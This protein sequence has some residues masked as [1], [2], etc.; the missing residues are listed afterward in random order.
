MTPEGR[1]RLMEAA[2]RLR[3]AASDLSIAAHKADD[4][5]AEELVTEVA[6]RAEDVRRAWWLP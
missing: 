6:I 1:A 4:R 3:A 5:A 2:E